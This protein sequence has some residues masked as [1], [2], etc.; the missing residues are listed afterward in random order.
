MR[1]A[2]PRPGR[3]RAVARA[4]APASSEARTREPQ[5]GVA[6][7]DRPVGL[8]EEA[9]AVQ[10]IP[11]CAPASVVG[12]AGERG[13]F[14]GNRRTRFVEG[15]EDVSDA[16]DAAIGRVVEFDQFDDLV[17][18]VVEAG[19]LSVQQ[20]S[21]PA[22]LPDGWLSTRVVAPGTAYR[23]KTSAMAAQIRCALKHH[24]SKR[25]RRPGPRRQRVNKSWRSAPNKTHCETFPNALG[26]AIAPKVQAV[27][28][29]R[30][31]LRIMC[32]RARAHAP[33]RP[34]QLRCPRRLPCCG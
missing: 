24:F 32:G 18:G 20:D 17:S 2:P 7:V 10:Q 6:V 31:A 8:A 3:S 1:S 9:G 30:P 19:G 15:G 29:R 4:P 16:A 11:S 34:D 26:A 25:L 23:L 33:S 5:A 13:N 14:R 12:D 22:I 21:S 28:S 27:V